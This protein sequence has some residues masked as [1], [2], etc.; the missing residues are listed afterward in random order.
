MATKRWAKKI[1]GKTRYF[2]P[3]DDSADFGASKALDK[4]RKQ[5]DDLHAGR[6]PQEAEKGLT[7]SR[8]INLFLAAK[9]RAVAAG[10]LTERTF[11]DYA[12]TLRRVQDT[13]GP[14]SLV[15]NLRPADFAKLATVMARTLGPASRGTEIRKTRC[16]FNHAFANELIDRP[17]RFG[18]C[19]K[20][21]GLS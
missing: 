5:A 20:P 4:Y 18:R 15:A 13:F 19:W 14:N 21:P 3:V 8:L 11:R 12:W 2:G 7:V 9:E 16:M 10:E 1:R 17:A 6:E